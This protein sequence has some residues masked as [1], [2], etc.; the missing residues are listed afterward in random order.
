KPDNP[1]QTSNNNPTVNTIGTISSLNCMSATANKSLMENVS[2]TNVLLTVPY[3]GGNGGK[4]SSM[5]INSIDVTGLTAKLD[6]GNFLLGNGSLVFKISGTPN[7]QGLAKFNIAIG[8]D[9]CEVELRVAPDFVS[10]SLQCTKII[11]SPIW[12]NKPISGTIEIPYSGG[13]GSSYPQLVVTSTGAVSGIVATLDAGTLTTSTGKLVF[14]LSGPTPTTNGYADFDINFKSKG[15]GISISAN[16]F[17]GFTYNLNGVPT[18]S[19]PYLKSTS[20]NVLLTFWAGLPF[21]QKMEII[22]S[23]FMEDNKTYDIDDRHQVSFGHWDG[24]TPFTTNMPGGYGTMKVIKMD[25]IA[26][27]AKVN[28]SGTIS[29]G[30]GQTKTITDGVFDFNY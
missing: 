2:V 29:N 4:F 17:L 24:T 16:D 20:S 30:L 9:T 26:R 21:A 1:N 27:Y 5:S 8:G 3:T 19:N 15:C 10:F 6:S 13:D 28:F 11:S 25:T 18:S 23:K 7:D 14:K 22:L 12:K